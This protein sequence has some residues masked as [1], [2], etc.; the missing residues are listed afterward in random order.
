MNGGAFLYHMSDFQL[1]LSGFGFSRVVV[2]R[3]CCYV[4]A[5]QALAHLENVLSE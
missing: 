2:G 1:L 5:G 3:T 4:P